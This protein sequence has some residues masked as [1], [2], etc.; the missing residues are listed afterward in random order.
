MPQLYQVIDDEAEYVL[1]I[2]EQKR[3]RPNSP[4]TSKRQHF[5]RAN[6]KHNRKDFEWYAP[7]DKSPPKNPQK[8]EEHQEERDPGRFSWTAPDM[9]PHVELPRIDGRKPLDL[10]LRPAEIKTRELA[11]ERLDEWSKD[12]EEYTMQQY[13]E[14]RKRILEQR[15]EAMRKVEE[16]TK[17]ELTELKETKPKEEDEARRKIAEEIQRKSDEQKAKQ[18]EEEKERQKKILEMR[19]AYQ[20]QKEETEITRK[21]NLIA[22]EERRAHWFEEH[23]TR[24][25]K[26][27]RF[28][29]ERTNCNSERYREMERERVRLQ[30]QK[31][32]ELAKVAER[33]AEIRAVMYRPTGQSREEEN[34]RRSSAEG[35]T[36]RALT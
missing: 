16:D 15:E 24:L 10:T 8:K 20:R 18:E 33:I 6:Q 14:V 28:R 3:R 30:K 34:D 35:A 26:D 1:V 32:Q 22:T 27:L 31:L 5:E 9:K 13:M 7:P 11:E 29:M 12:Q 17:R 21:E 4:G 2:E 19:A 36:G 25:D 23:F